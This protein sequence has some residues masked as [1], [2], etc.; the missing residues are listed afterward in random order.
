MQALGHLVATDWFS[1]HVPWW[2][3]Y[4]GLG[5]PLAGDMQSGAFF[6]PTL[7]FASAG[8]AG[9]VPGGRWS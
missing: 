4:E 1:G 2:N 5:V 9:L 6:P 7:L 8:R 3:P